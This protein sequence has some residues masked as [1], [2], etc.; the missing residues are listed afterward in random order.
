MSLRVVLIFNPHI[1]HPHVSM[2][3]FINISLVPVTHVAYRDWC[4]VQLKS[5]PKQ[6]RN[7]FARDYSNALAWV[8]DVMRK[9]LG[10]HVLLREERVISCEECHPRGHHKQR[11]FELDAVIA[12]DTAL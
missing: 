4:T 10:Q 11:Y 5:R 3:R 6:P 7:A 9:M 8:E 1:A 12:H 2:S